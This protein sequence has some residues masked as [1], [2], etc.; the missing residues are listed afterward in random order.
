MIIAWE[1]FNANLARTIHSIALDFNIPS[2]KQPD[3]FWVN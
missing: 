2:I 1:D 3:V